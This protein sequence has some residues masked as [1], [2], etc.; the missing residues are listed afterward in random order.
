MYLDELIKKL[1]SPYTEDGEE[2]ESI[3]DFDYTIDGDKLYIFDKNEVYSNNYAEDLYYQYVN[4]YNDLKYEFPM[5]KPNR[6]NFEDNIF[7]QIQEA[8]KKDGYGDLDWETNTRMICVKNA[9]HDAQEWAFNVYE[10]GEKV[11]SYKTKNEAFKSVADK[12]NVVIRMERFT[13]SILTSKNVDDLLEK[14]YDEFKKCY[15]DGEAEY[16]ERFYELLHKL[17]ELAE[18]SEKELI[19]YF[20]ENYEMESAV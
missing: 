15:N 16:S 14:T 1:N 12:D 20:V 13:D 4:A 18:S 5:A 10:N 17:S 6:S 19:D 9:V 11:G 3:F 7:P 2:Y 8:V